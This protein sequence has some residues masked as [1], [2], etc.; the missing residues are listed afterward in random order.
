MKKIQEGGVSH[1]VTSRV[2]WPAPR[3]AWGACDVTSSCGLKWAR[4]RSQKCGPGAILG[5]K[6]FEFQMLSVDTASRNNLSF[7]HK[8]RNNNRRRR[9]QQH[10][11]RRSCF[12]TVAQ[13]PVLIQTANRTNTSRKL[14]VFTRNN[15]LASN[16]NKKQRVAETARPLGIGTLVATIKKRT[17]TVTVASSFP[18]SLFNRFRSVNKQFDYNI[19]KTVE[20]MISTVGIRPI[21]FPRLN[22]FAKKSLV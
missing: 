18:L 5:P 19:N 22:H 1:P 21:I 2:T 10:K 8:L 9:L 6:R 16:V 15:C 17:P 20:G 14:V 3:T 12:F 13:P 4:E 11:T 7:L